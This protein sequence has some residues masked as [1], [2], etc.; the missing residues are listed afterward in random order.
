M[1]ALCYLNAPLSYLTTLLTTPL[2]AVVPA[3]S[4]AFDVDSRSCSRSHFT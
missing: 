1:Q 3:L 2:W 4:L